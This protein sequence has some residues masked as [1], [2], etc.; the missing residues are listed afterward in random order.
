MDGSFDAFKEKLDNEHS[1][2][3]TY[4]FKFVVPVAKESEF[5]DIFPSFNFET[6]HSKTGKYISFTMKKEMQSSEGVVEIYLRAKKIKG[7][8]A[9]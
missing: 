6:K 2:P 5:R 9:L 1:W 7:L 3:A 4:M 8:I